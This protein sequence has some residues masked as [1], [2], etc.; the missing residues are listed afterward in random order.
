MYEQRRHDAEDSQEVLDLICDHRPSASSTSHIQSDRRP[1]ASSTSYTQSDRRP[2]ASST[3][4]TQSD[5]SLSTTSTSHGIANPV[6]RRS[7]AVG[8]LT[9]ALNNRTYCQNPDVAFGT[10]HPS[11]LPVDYSR[12]PFSR[13]EIRIAG[14]WCSKYNRDHPGNR[15]TAR[16]FLNYINRT[17]EVA[18]HYHPRH[19]ADST[20]IRPAYR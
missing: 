2:S 18:V 5:R 13:M 16:E 3:S 12:V 14:E 19:L 17:P 7:F 9:D 4:H 15:S 6:T 1:S 20:R 8:S 11:H 10:M